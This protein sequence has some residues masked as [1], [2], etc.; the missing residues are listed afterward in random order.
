MRD[1]EAR[2][3]KT[4]PGAR[5]LPRTGLR[6][7]INDFR[8]DVKFRYV[9]FRGYYKLRAY[10]YMRGGIPDL[11]L[12]RFLIDRRKDSI[13]VGANLGLY[14]YFMARYSKHVYAFEPNPYPLRILKSVVDRNVS[15]QPI[16]ITDRSGT[17][18]L[19]VPKGRKGW[20][21]NGASL[22]HGDEMGGIEIE[23]PCASID[24]FDY[25]GIG[26]IKIDIEGHEYAALKGATRT[27]E[28]ERPNLLIEN[29]ASH[30][31]T[32]TDRVFA[33]LRDL[34]YEGFTLIDGVLTRLEKFSFAEH[35]SVALAGSNSSGYAK[36]FIFLPR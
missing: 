7:W 19:R 12:L 18:R 13:D 15:V 14:T 6:D 31:G 4:M 30:V 32:D 26:F 1:D 22:E 3:A 5:A 36:N 34:D 20:S 11:G 35:Q 16:A 27:L 10:K 25:R 23:V 24:E 8:Q 17:A 33:A 9:P 21:S 2:T 29:E 28:R